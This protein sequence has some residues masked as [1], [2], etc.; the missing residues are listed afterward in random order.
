MDDSCLAQKTRDR[1][2]RDG[3]WCNLQPLRIPTML[4]SSCVANGAYRF[5]VRSSQSPTLEI[6][7]ASRWAVLYLFDLSLPRIIPLT[8]STRFSSSDN[9]GVRTGELLV[10]R[11]DARSE[12]GPRC[13]GCCAAGVRDWG[14]AIGGCVRR[15]N[16]GLGWKWPGW[17][18]KGQHTSAKSEISNHSRRLQP[19]ES[20]RRVWPRHAMAVIANAQRSCGSN[21]RQSHAF[22]A[23]TGILPAMAVRCHENRP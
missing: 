10:H 12:R 13:L 22:T 18:Y 11:V 6:R 4:C 21:L 2:S 8:Q 1:L 7:D 16:G 23:R 20:V 17:G 5:G 9:S 19:T 3:G 14:T 15:R